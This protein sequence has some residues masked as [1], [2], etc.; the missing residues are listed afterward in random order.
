V[1]GDRSNVCA[2]RC[3]PQEEWVAWSESHLGA[4]TR[5]DGARVGAG[6][7]CMDADNGT[8]RYQPLQRIQ[9]ECNIPTS[10]RLCVAGSS[11]SGRV[12]EVG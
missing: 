1:W 11:S 10:V 2:S 8:L 9:A 3:H 5:S 7:Q 6:E 4:C 12:W